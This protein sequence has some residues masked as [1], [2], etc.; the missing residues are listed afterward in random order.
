MA[1]RLI[2]EE[3]TWKIPQLVHLVSVFNLALD[4]DLTAVSF[5]FTPRLLLF[6]PRRRLPRLTQLFVSPLLF[7]LLG[8]R[9]A[10]L[11]LEY[12]VFVLRA[13]D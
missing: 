12:V 9:D 4:G 8:S 1:T 6:T 5:V 11:C 10:N 7:I 13:R 3:W 2:W